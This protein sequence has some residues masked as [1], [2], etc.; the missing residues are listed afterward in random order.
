[1]SEFQHTPGPWI[2][3]EYEVRHPITFELRKGCEIFC[4]DNNRVVCEIPDYHFHKEDVANQS[5]DARL[6]TTAPEILEALVAAVTFIDSHVADPDITHKMRIA[7]E[8][9]RNA[10]PEAAIAKA[11]GEA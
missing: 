9:Y 7:Y 3:S 11:R 2:L 8:A 6:I 10:K 5:A 1:M 4:K